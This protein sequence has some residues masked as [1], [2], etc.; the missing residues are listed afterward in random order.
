MTKELTY[1]KVRYS[2]YA[3]KELS[4]LDS[5]QR[6]IIVKWVYKHL[7]GTHNPMHTGKG[8]SANKKGK[9]RYRVGKYRLIADIDAEEITILILN[10]SHRNEVYKD[11]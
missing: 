2:K 6:N 10:I 3:Q 5:Q 8:L 7:E 11:N 1:Y 9:W 4:K